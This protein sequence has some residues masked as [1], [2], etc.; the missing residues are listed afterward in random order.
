M[1]PEMPI[2]ALRG[3]LPEAGVWLAFGMMAGLAYLPSADDQ[4]NATTVVRFAMQGMLVMGLLFV[5]ET[6]VRAR[7]LADRLAALPFLVGW[8]AR[9]LIATV[10]I[11]FA[12]GVGN[13]LLTH[14]AVDTLDRPPPLGDLVYAVGAAA[15]FQIVLL[16]RAAIGGRVLLNALFGRYR[17]PLDERRIFLVLDLA[18]S[19]GIAAR[20]GAHGMHRL[21]SC[22]FADVATV[23]QRFGGETHAYI[24]DQAIIT[25]PMTGDG[26]VD[27]RAIACGRAIFETTTRREA[28]YQAQFG[29]VP[30]FRI[31]VH[32][33]AVVA[34]ECGL[35]RR[36]IV[37]YGDAIITAVRLQDVGRASGHA[38]VV[39][40]DLLDR[41]VLPKGC[42]A[43][44]L[45]VHG[46]RGRPDPLRVAALDATGGH[47]AAPA[48]LEPA[49]S[50]LPP[51]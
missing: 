46:L 4:A 2:T 14:D 25:W 6:V 15:V 11:A 42:F 50:S 43:T 35:D 8:A 32:G 12:L 45:G 51:A 24:G 28:R 16:V 21:L 30:R 39:S 9:S 20:L 26:I 23:T 3:R 47:A 18:G 1:G 19:T 38:M 27:A 5:S 34:G 31:T 48:A 44:D 7:P 37:Y 13:A 10:V 22:F 17:R 29:V 33:G 40:G 36:Q 41:I 49:W